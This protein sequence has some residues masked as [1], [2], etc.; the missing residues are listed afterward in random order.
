VLWLCHLIAH[1]LIS[2]CTLLRLR[3]A[4]SAKAA[5]DSKEFEHPLIMLAL[6]TLGTFNFVNQELSV[7]C[8]LRDLVVFYLD[9]DTPLIRREAALTACKLITRMSGDTNPVGRSSSQLL[10]NCVRSVLF[11]AVSDPIPAIR[12][13][14]LSAF[15][16]AL[17][18]YISQS[19]L[20]QSLF[21]AIHDPVFA[22]REFV[23]T[24]LGRLSARNPAIILPF[25]RKL[26]IQLLDALKGGDFDMP[27]TL[28]H[29][30]ESAKLMGHV[31]SSC[32]LL[33]RSY[34][35]TILQVI[36]PKLAL[37]DKNAYSKQGATL[38]SY[39]LSTIG[40]LAAICGE[41]IVASTPTLMPIIIDALIDKAAPIKRH[42][43]PSSRAECC[44]CSLTWRQFCFV[45][46]LC[47][48][49]GSYP[50]STS[51]VHRLCDRLC[52]RASRAV[53]DS[54]GRSE[55]RASSAAPQRCSESDRHYRRCGP[56]S[57][58]ADQRH[59]RSERAWWR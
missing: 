23:I 20:L 55:E 29:L 37:R 49:C 59:A 51:L 19:E 8:Y 43:P 22:I 41:E 9:S 58:Q 47:T 27:V 35:P 12:M 53:A 21:I 40:K 10:L 56:A 45:A 14:V 28:A 46:C 3:V 33:I 18:M 34:V 7:L 4:C 25:M 50:W 52:D 36:L 15:E 6:K 13:H 44:G 39:L 42:V 26:I 1:P 17:D 30:E 38:S 31:I 48:G 11:I 32:P 57:F 2:P 24:L 54:S 16:P 5:N